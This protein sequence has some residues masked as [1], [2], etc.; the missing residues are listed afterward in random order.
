M[1]TACI[2]QQVLIIAGRSLDAQPVGKL[3]RCR[4]S[5]A[6]HTHHFNGAEPPQRLGVDAA[7]E[8]NPKN[9]YLCLCHTLSNLLRPRAM[10]FNA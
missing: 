4:G 9:C 10:L 3:T 1:W 7:H 5:A 6:S 8:T 2:G